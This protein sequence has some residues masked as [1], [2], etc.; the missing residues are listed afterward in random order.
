MMANAAIQLSTEPYDASGPRPLGRNSA[1]EGFLRGF[2]KYA[3]V[4]R[5]QFW[6]AHGQDQAEL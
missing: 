6:N 5:F 3:V 1:G 2:L 4:D